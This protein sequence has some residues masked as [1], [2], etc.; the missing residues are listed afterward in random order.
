MIHRG[1][2]WND[3]LD[4]PGGVRSEAEGEG[5]AGLPLPQENVE[6]ACR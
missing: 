4:A 5:K 1:G 3:D 6:T 2:Q